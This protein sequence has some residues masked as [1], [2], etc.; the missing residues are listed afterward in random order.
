MRCKKVMAPCIFIFYL[1][2]SMQG[3]SRFPSTSAEHDDH[4]VSPVVPLLGDI[5][6]PC[7][8]HLLL[9]FPLLLP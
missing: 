8:G 5:M 1:P 4:K 3:K 2:S 7:F 6:L 9:P